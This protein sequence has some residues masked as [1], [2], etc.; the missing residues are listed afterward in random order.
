MK[1][2]PVRLLRCLVVASLTVY[3]A[4]AL[5]A[6][7]APT[8]SGYPAVSIKLGGTYY[9][10]PSANDA[11]RNT[12][13]FSI[14]NKPSWAT[15]SS[16]TG[17]LTGKPPTF[18]K[19]SNIVIQ[20]SDGQASAQLP[21]FAI[22]A[23]TAPTISGTPVTSTTVGN[24]YSFT[25][26]AQDIDG[27]VLSFS[28]TNKPAWAAFDTLTGRLSGTPTA[29]SSTANI[30]ISVSDGKATAALA[31]FTLVVN[32]DRVTL[33]WYP[34]TTNIDGSALTNLN[35]YKIYY[36]TSAAALTNSVTVPAG[37]SSYVVTGLTGGNW[38]FAMAS[39]NSVGT[40]SAL[41]SILT[42]TI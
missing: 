11:D 36:G 16:S 3:A 13:W 34:P 25:P 27:S 12:L 4:P 19:W 6:N 8:I 15:F 18:G 38:Y 33:S 22:T 17:L 35:K 37:V 20:V 26:S 14:V 31:P 40:E 7:S 2:S 10:Q 1:C 42:K 39:I 29:I 41:S 23:W 21:A 24:S 32:G 30:V 28:V 5:S 9:F